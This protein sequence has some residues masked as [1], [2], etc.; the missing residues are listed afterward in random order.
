MKQYCR[1]CVFCFEADDFGC[2][3]HPK[4][5]EPHWSENDI[6]RENHCKNFVLSDLGDVITG[7]QYKPREYKPRSKEQWE[8]MKFNL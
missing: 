1:Y 7:K 5:K 4:G 8:Q 3:N 2:S 6:K